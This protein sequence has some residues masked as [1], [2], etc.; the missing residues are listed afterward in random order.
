MN[1]TID[2]AIHNAIA[3]VNLQ[4]QSGCQ[5]AESETQ[6]LIGDGSVLDSLGILLFVTALETNLK[7]A[8]PTINL[9]DLL[10]NADNSVHF[11]SV[12]TLKQYLLGLA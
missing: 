9:V 11:A 7:P 2:T 5:M 4:Q 1:N 10:M 3:E 8:L 6:V 12:G